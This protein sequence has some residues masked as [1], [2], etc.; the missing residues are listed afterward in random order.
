MFYRGHFILIK[1]NE[2]SAKILI[3]IIFTLSVS[4]IFAETK[5]Q[6]IQEGTITKLFVSNDPSDK[7]DSQRVMVRLGNDVSGGHCPKK[8]FWQMLLNNSAEKAQ[9]DLLLSSYM[10]GK[11]VKI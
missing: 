8:V 1:S 11:K 2:R 5:I 3:T 4:N 9:Y 7:F 6:A 10:N